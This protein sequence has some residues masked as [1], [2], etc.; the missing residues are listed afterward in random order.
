MQ[1]QRSQSRLQKIQHP[2]DPSRNGTTGDFENPE[3]L[4]STAKLSGLQR[5]ASSIKSEVDEINGSNP[6]P[7]FP[8]LS[9]TSC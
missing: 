3:S 9:A 7:F 5:T 1:P 8:K 2:D 4:E 6:F